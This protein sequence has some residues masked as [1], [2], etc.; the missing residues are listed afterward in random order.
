MDQETTYP[1]SNDI[2]LHSHQQ[3][4]ENHHNSSDAET[5]LRKRHTVLAVSD[6]LDSFGDKGHYP[7]KKESC[8]TQ[9]HMDHYKYIF[10]QK[11]QLSQTEIFHSLI[12]CKHGNP[13]YHKPAGWPRLMSDKVRNTDLLCTF[14]F[15]VIVFFPGLPPFKNIHNCGSSHNYKSPLKTI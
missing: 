13:L 2:Y 1:N 10:Q 9:M 11:L 3:P 7:I 5:Q 6:K 12:Q 14:F 8:K 15:Q 4:I